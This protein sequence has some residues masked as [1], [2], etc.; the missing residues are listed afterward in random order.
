[1]SSHTE[2]FTMGVEEEY[3]IVDP[4]T[5]ELSSTADALLQQAKPTLGDSIQPELNLSQVESVSP[6]CYSLSEVR[7]VLIRM[8]RE[9]NQ[10]AQ[11]TGTRIAAA[12]THPFSHWKNQ[13]ITPKERYQSIA[14]EYQQLALEPYFGYHVHVGLEDQE[15]ALQIL[16]R[17]RA[18]LGSLLALSANSPFW[19]GDVTGYASYRTLLWSQ[20]A[21]SGPP[22]TFASL[23]EYR[24][25]AQAMIDIGAIE[26]PSK[27]YWDVRLSAR[28][29]TVEF[30]VADACLTIDTAVMLAGLIRALVSTLNAQVLRNEPVFIPRP[31]VVRVAHWQAARYGLSGNLIDVIAQRQ[32]PAPTLITQLLAF[33]RPALEE[34]GDWQEVSHLVHDTLRYG[35]GA[36]RQLAVYEQ[37]KRVEDVVDFIIDETAKITL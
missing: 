9:I 7:Q 20:W 33:V 4:V 3:Q 37:T 19:L 25:M 29:R 23:A 26:D 28:F 31:E 11:Q 14:T 15:I 21:T 32:V 22:L 2:I 34:A 17:S 36:A 24:E 12:G 6:I 27:L 30:R 1:M 18:W 5:R 16:N 10:F 35:N 13:Q 8:R